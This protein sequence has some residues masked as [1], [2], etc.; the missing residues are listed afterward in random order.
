MFVV[1]GSL[2]IYNSGT[3]GDTA[4]PGSGGSGTGATPSSPG[5]ADATPVFNYSGT[6]N[7]SSTTGPIAGALPATVP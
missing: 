3:S 7:G 6:V 1:A 2:T 4:T 5:T